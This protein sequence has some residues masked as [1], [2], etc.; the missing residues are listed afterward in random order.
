MSSSVVPP[1]IKIELDKANQW[2]E[3]DGKRLWLNRDRF[4]ST[5]P[6]N[7]GWMVASTE[8]FKSSCS[9]SCSDDDE[10]Q[11]VPGDRAK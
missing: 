5:F 7:S 11:S 1:R 8:A 10:S 9:G 6:R 3:R 2:V 4:Q